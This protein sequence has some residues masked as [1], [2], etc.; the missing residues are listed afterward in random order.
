MSSNGAAT[1]FFFFYYLAPLRSA[2]A[3]FLALAFFALV[4]P[5]RSPSFESSLA[6]SLDSS[7]VGVDGVSPGP[8]GVEGADGGVVVSSGVS[9]VSPGPDG[10]GG[11]MDGPPAP[12][13][14]GPIEGG[15]EDGPPAPGAP[16]GPIEGGGPGVGIINPSSGNSLITKSNLAA[17]AGLFM[18]GI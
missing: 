11:V 8:P 9:G 15:V 18:D 4:A 12:G 17:I 14:P 3:T 6:S 16:P 10:D 13:G 1:I 2:L 5:L 7:S